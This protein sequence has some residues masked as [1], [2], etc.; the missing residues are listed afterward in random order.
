MRSRNIMYAFNDYYFESEIEEVVGNLY[1][2]GELPK[3]DI[4]SYKVDV[5]EHEPVITSTIDIEYLMEWVFDKWGEERYD[6]NHS[7]EDRIQAVFE[8]HINF[9]AINEELEKIK[10]YYPSG[11]TYIITEEDYLSTFPAKKD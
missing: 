10:L 5:C 11:E 9:Q 4:I 8:K 1:E 3:E 6:E 2:V 7:A